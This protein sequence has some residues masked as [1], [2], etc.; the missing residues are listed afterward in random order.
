[1]RI[2]LSSLLVLALSV[3]LALVVKDDNGYVLL[4][5]GQWTVE[6]SLAFFVLL[7]LALFVALYLSIRLGSRFLAM[8]QR[9]KAWRNRRSTRKSQRSLTQGL[10]E[11]S[12]GDWQRA[13]RD[14]TRFAA[15]SETPLLNY[16]AAARSAQKQGAHERRD[17]YLQLAHESMPSAEM[18]V[19]LTQ[20]ELQLAHDQFEQAL[21]TLK[22]L[23][24]IAPRHTYVL[25]LLKDLYQQLE[26]W[27]A[28]QE[29][30]PEL[31]KRKVV[32][33]DEMADLEF[34]IYNHLLKQG[35]ERGDALQ[36]AAIWKQIPLSARA[37]ETLTVRYADVLLSW[38]ENEAAERLIR[39]AIDR[40][41][42]DA[43]VSRYGA[44]AAADNGRQLSTAEG[45]L[46][47]HTKDSVL[48]LALGRI[49]L[50]NKLWGKA[51]SYL[52]ASIGV[53]PSVAA[54]HE[55]GSLL[56]QMDEPE[57]AAN[58]YKAGLGLA[59]RQGEGGDAPQLRTIEIPKI[60]RS[61]EPSVESPRLEVVE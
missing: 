4:G 50:R 52:E 1:M 44:L 53:A 38:E 60:G 13:E 5:Y 35:A 6:G 22:H 37:D 45:W 51:R 46:E 31:K 7:N 32:T 23:R 26:D 19:G 36:L 54:Y 43:L 18:A 40:Q 16:L 58:C 34:T 25:K 17:H 55:L 10:V 15:N 42:S 29:L 47:A 61:E 39:E 2:L 59:S 9:L 33:Q 28:L 3:G 41:W 8:P 27:Q 14:L 11:L 24:Q 21:A 20:A 49:S 56:E 57:Q 12:E 48:L 30:L